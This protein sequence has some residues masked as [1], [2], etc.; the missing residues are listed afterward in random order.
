LLVIALS[1]RIIEKSCKNNVDGSCKDINWNFKIKSC[2]KY[3][4]NILII[5][6]SIFLSIINSISF[7]LNSMFGYEIFL[8]K[9]KWMK[10]KG[11]RERMSN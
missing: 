3:D 9:N 10:N 7:W 5:L 11:K 8:K 1:F 6:K 2:I 4:K